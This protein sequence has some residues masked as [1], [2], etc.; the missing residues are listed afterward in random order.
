VLSTSASMMGQILDRLDAGVE[1][2]R[3]VGRL[4]PTR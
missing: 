3:V 4:S 1:W 2:I